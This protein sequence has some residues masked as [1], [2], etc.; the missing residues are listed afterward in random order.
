M[1]I[2][3]PSTSKSLRIS[4]LFLFQQKYH[5]HGEELPL[6]LPTLIDSSSAFL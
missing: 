2:S 4:F 3:G 1:I 5:F 6:W